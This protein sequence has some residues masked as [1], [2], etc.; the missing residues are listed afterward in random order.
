MATIYP[1]LDHPLLRQ[2]THCPVC[3][4]RKD[5]GLVICWSCYRDKGMRYG[6]P[7]VDRIVDRAEDGLAICERLER[8]ARA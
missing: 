1:A 2:S 4:D 8:E 7:T 6:N 3:H 5:N